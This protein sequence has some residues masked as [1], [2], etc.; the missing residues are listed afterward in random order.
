MFDLDQ[1]IA[2]WRRQMQAAGI[3]SSETLA[4]LESHLRED[5]ER[6]MQSGAGEA[7]AF[8]AAL[9][10]IGAVAAL[11]IEFTKTRAGIGATLRH[12]IYT[13]AGI[14]HPQ[15]VTNMNSTIPNFEP[16]WA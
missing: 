3:K 15:L 8:A 7:K 6:K 2:N 12:L 9:E 11:Q 1:A 10:Q 16:R 5:V 4:E 13:L 14:P